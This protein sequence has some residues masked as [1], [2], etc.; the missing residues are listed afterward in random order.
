[1][2][3]ILQLLLLSVTEKTHST[4]ST[5]SSARR[6]VKKVVGRSRN[7]TSL[8]GMRIQSAMLANVRPPPRSRSPSLGP[9]GNGTAASTSKASIT[10]HSNPYRHLSH[11][12]LIEIQ[13][14][15]HRPPTVPKY[16][17]EWHFADA[18]I[19]INYVLNNQEQLHT[20]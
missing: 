13:R 16:V 18:K 11:R 4:R 10:V 19:L 17:S 8:L 14:P 3:V 9:T 1:M 2:L 5:S 12:H 7:L 15:D 6:H 20:G